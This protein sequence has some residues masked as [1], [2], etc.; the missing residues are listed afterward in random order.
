MSVGNKNHQ[1]DYFYLVKIKYCY[2]S[3][4]S[5]RMNREIEEKEMIQSRRIQRGKGYYGQY[6]LDHL[7]TNELN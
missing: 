6:I 3:I 5:E 7:K 2:A 1:K 4:L